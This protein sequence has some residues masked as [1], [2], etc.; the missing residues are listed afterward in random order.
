MD[1]DSMKIA[2][3]AYVDLCK[4]FTESL[5]KLVENNP[6]LKELDVCTV[7]RAKVMG[8]SLTTVL[9][10]AKID[11]LSTLMEVMHDATKTGTTHVATD[12]EQH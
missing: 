9:L 10:G 12:S 1:N 7:F 4:G 6:V 5:H 3:D 2:M 8:K 11:V